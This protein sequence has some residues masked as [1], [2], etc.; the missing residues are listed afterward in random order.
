MI[1]PDKKTIFA[2]ETLAETGLER[3]DT[4]RNGFKDPWFIYSVSEE[5]QRGM[6]MLVFGCGM[7]IPYSILLLTSNN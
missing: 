3:S 6:N 4:Y 2:A 7:D 5:T 1:F